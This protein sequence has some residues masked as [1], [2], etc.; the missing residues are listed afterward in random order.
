MKYSIFLTATIA[1]I[2]GLALGASII[3]S[4]QTD[5]IVYTEFMV[6]ENCT[7][8]AI[9]QFPD[10]TTV[11]FNTTTQTELTNIDITGKHFGSY[12]DYQKIYTFHIG[13]T[14]EEEWQLLGYTINVEETE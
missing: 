4:Q 14:S 5:P 8:N 12:Q 13:Y 7:I 9:E 2:V 10:Y 1:F 6:L 3:S 11:Y